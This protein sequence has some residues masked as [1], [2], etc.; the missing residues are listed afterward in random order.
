MS[1]N[2]VHSVN[3][4]KNQNSKMTCQELSLFEE[5]T[6]DML[7]VTTIISSRVVQCS[8][9]DARSYPGNFKLKKKKRQ[10]ATTPRSNQHANS[11]AGN[12]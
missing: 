11:N 12:Q 4:S 1:R 10:A 9:R 7:A 6:N 3:A 8:R 2:T 5:N